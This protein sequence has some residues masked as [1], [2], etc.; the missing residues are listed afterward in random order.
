MDSL[1]GRSLG[2]YHLLEQLGEGGMATVYKAFDT[3]LER[4]VAIKVIRTDLDQDPQFLSRFDREA[5]A[6]ARLSHPQIV[7]V[8][9]AGESDGIPFV[10][11]D[12]VKGGTLKQQ[13]GSPMDPGSAARM[14]APIARALEHAHTQGII[15]RDIKP[16]NILLSEDGR[17]MLSDFGIA[18]LLDPQTSAAGLTMTGVGIGTPDYM[19]PEQGL[20]QA[21]PQTD[22]YALGVVFYEM[23][24]GRRPYAGDTPIAVLLK[25]A[26]DPLPRPRDLVPDLPIEVERVLLRA[27]AKKPEDRYPDMAALATALEG[28]T[29]V[30]RPQG[31][32]PS[33][34]EGRSTSR[35]LIVALGLALVG[36]VVCGG[37]LVVAWAALG[38]LRGPTTAG[39]ADPGPTPLTEAAPAPATATDAP[40]E[41]TAIPAAVA[42]ATIA[43][44]T[45]PAPA[46]TPVPVSD[47]DGMPQVYIPGGKFV[48]GSRNEVLALDD[49]W[50]DQTE[51]TNAMYAR[52]V[53]AGICSAPSGTSSETRAFYFQNPEFD[54][55]PVVYV[56]WDD[57][58]AYCNWVGRRLPTGSEWEKAARG[59]DGRLYPWGDGS[60]NGGLANYDH[61]V[62]DTTA[63]GSY[64][65]GASAYGVL[66]LAGNVSE[67]VDEWQDTGYR[68]VR[69]GSW[70]SDSVGIGAVARYG[71]TPT[72]KFSDYGFR[73]A[74]RTA[75]PGWTPPAAID[76]AQAAG[77]RVASGPLLTNFR[78]CDRPCTEPG[79]QEIALYP[80]QTTQVFVSWDYTG[81]QPETPYVRSWSFAGQEWVRY[82][83]IWRGPESGTFSI[84][85]WDNEGLRSGTWTLTV[86][87]DAAH[88]FSF[89]VPIDG[90][91]TLFTPAG[92]PACPDFR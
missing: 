55:H 54:N 67:W 92:Q 8:L 91:F 59:T 26:T 36:L 86:T 52:C 88:V 58:Q 15:H 69:G 2:R 75:P 11:M 47:R 7:H 40:P 63:V 64:P 73:C 57:A 53:A 13:L 61:Q 19:A 5:K 23:V 49:F 66:D 30:T 84:R 24:T 41:P 22:L 80:E 79:A 90:A 14:L 50:I 76:P 33:G 25:H 20:G 56:S 78:T 65:E 32:R 85:L 51:V 71:V 42:A 4:T 6:L 12:F 48:I 38:G 34:G 37:A 21:T 16:A 28:L 89:G 72:R 81:L 39:T 60:P 43:P 45:P 46:A 31:T 44:T 18:K 74:T 35:P 83:C 82:H 29:D 70:T 9:D 77:T 87:F 68:V 3:R 17:A 10:V 1:S 62:G 27:L